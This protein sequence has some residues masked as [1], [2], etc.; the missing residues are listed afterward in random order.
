MITAAVL[1]ATPIPAA[2]PQ[3]TPGAV[4]AS[5]GPALQTFELTPSTGS[6]PT[7]ESLDAPLQA[8]AGAAATGLAVSRR[9]TRPFALVGVTWT[10]PRRRLDGTVEVR[11]RAAADGRW[12]GW[13][14]LD[15]DE[16]TA[17]TTL[18][19]TDGLD[20]HRIR[21]WLIAER[22]VVTTAADFARAPFEL[23][24][25]VLR[26][27]PHVDVTADELQLLVESL[28]AATTAA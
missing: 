1:A 12:T 4:P 15:V 27:S 3:A 28:A 23:R 11:T 20:P 8:R 9:A 21:A 13:R 5:P 10:D 14:A 18:Q 7:G 17:I 26:V 6:A 22:G 19:S 2:H 24:A 16:P 25:P